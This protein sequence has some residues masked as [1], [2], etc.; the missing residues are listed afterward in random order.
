MKR[1]LVTTIAGAA[2]LAL[3]TACG[4][5]ST[6]QAADGPQTIKVALW[7]YATTPEFKAIIDGFQQANPQIKIE[8][9]K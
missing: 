9:V 8:P 4:G 3:L 7:N 1:H 5:G 2:A 6:G